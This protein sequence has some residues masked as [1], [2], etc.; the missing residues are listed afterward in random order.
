MAML[1]EHRGIITQEYLGD[2]VDTFPQMMES[3]NSHEDLEREMRGLQ[4]ESDDGPGKSDAP[5]RKQRRHGPERSQW[6]TIWYPTF[7]LNLDI[8]KTLP[9]G[10]VE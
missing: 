1:R 9:P 5:N 2:L 8:K 4:T 7:A 6:A 3:A 10:G